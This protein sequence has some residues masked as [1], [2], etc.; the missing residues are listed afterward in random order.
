MH[1]ARSDLRGSGK[2]ERADR[3]GRIVVAVVAELA[4]GI[5]APAT[6]RTSFHRAGMVSSDGYAGRRRDAVLDFRHGLVDGYRADSGIIETVGG[7]G[8]NRSVHVA[9]LRSR[10]TENSITVVPPTLNLSVEEEC[11]T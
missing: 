10:G 6:Y 5:V 11:T 7:S 9:V 4:F 2:A 3:S 1:V 8:E